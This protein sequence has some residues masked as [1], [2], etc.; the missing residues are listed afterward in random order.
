MLG[1]GGVGKTALTIQ[2]TSNH[3]VE[4]YDPTIEDC[5]RKHCVIDN[6]PA[7]LELLDTAGQEEFTALRDQWIRDSEAY[8]IVYSVTSQDSLDLVDGIVSSIKRVKDDFDEG[9]SPIVLAGNKCDLEEKREVSWE[10]GNSVA[11]RFG[12]QFFETSA[13][14]RYNLEKVFFDVVRLIREQY[15]MKAPKKSAN[16]KKKQKCLVL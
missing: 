9:M 11:N 8:V 12:L 16:T 7:F 5:Y 2:F 1:D 13:K 15:E 6:I 3:F 4:D 10:E 14:T